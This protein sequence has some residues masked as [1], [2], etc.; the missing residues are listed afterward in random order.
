MPSEN[1]PGT[2]I[3]FFIAAFFTALIALCMNWRNSRVLPVLYCI[4]SIPHSPYQTIKDHQLRRRYA[5]NHQDAKKFRRSVLSVIFVTRI[6]QQNLSQFRAESPSHRLEVGGGV[7]TSPA[8]SCELRYCWYM[9]RAWLLKAISDE[10]GNYSRCV[11]QSSNP[12]KHVRR[13]WL[14]YIGTILYIGTSNSYQ[15]LFW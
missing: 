1:V 5:T 8:W 7:M 2:K 14:V 12:I 6:S 15:S 11:S 13:W 10:P 9:V 4:T 3:L